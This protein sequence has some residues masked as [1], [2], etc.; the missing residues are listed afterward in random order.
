[1]HASNYSSIDGQADFYDER[2]AQDASLNRLNGFQLARAAAIFKAL[3]VLDRTF[4]IHRLQPFRVCDL[5][6]GRGW[7]TSQL[8]SVGQVTGVDLSPGGIKIAAEKWPDINFECA[9]ILDWTSSEPFDLIVSS[10][11]IEHIEAKTSLVRAIVRN[12]KPGGFVIITTPNARA[13]AAWA[14]GGQLTQPIEEWPSRRELRSLFTPEFDVLSHETFVHAYTYLGVHRFFSAPKL[15]DFLRRTGML[16]IYQGI[17]TTLGVGL[18]Q[19][20][21]AQRK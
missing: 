18:H 12:L 3:S 1:M 17:Q 19:V 2:W 20:L 13:K 6:C 7:M 16:P 8:S 4:K 21:I 5:G 15:L 14:E 10:E 11:V 9:N